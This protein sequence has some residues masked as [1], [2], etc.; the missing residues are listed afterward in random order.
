MAVQTLK[1]FQNLP[2]LVPLI[3]RVRNLLVA[4]TLAFGTVNPASAQP[5]S[6]WREYIGAH[7]SEREWARSIRDYQGPGAAGINYPEIET[8]VRQRSA[9][10]SLGVAETLL[11]NI[12][13]LG[14]GRNERQLAAYMDAIR[15]QGGERWKAKVRDHVIEFANS[16]RSKDIEIYWQFGNE[17]NSGQ[18]SRSFHQWARDDERPMGHDAKTIS[19]YVEYFLAPGVEGIIEARE[20]RPDL[21]NK[22][23]IVLGSLGV[24]RNPSAV[25]W[26]NR[27]LEYEVRGSYAPSL[28][29]KKVFELVNVVSLHYLVGTPGDGWRSILDDL[30]NRWYRTGAIKAIWSTEEIGIRRARAGY[31]AATAMQ[32]LARYMD[33]WAS[34]GIGPNAGK[35][36][37]WG[38]DVGSGLN[39]A[40]YVLGEIY[41]FIGNGRIVPIK[42]K[43][44]IKGVGDI[45]HYRFLSPDA[46]GK[47]LIML[48][49]KDRDLVRI[50]KLTITVRNNPKRINADMM[51]LN[52]LANGRHKLRLEHVN[53]RYLLN[54]ATPIELPVGSAV[55]IML[56]S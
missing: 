1:T 32:V 49:P 5:S 28:K 56:S 12:G 3:S 38:S 30:H 54:P 24:A 14:S 40:D 36:F 7:Y 18:F 43:V 25:E 20:R 37:F 48:F 31:G 10:G 11:F 45:E 13:G 47:Q 42:D 22:L 46:S 29:G 27:L 35:V 51:I 8:R 53:G 44:E 19:W 34:K 2:K 41:N 55:L 15:A 52:P 33:W 39:K 6:E 50:D 23:N 4:F 17:I 21:R 9:M 16:Y 26:L